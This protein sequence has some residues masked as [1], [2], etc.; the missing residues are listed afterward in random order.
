MLSEKCLQSLYQERMS[1][2]EQACINDIHELL[3]ERADL[4]KNHFPDPKDITTALKVTN[5]ITKHIQIQ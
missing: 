1:I 4:F 5:Q 2:I 3:L